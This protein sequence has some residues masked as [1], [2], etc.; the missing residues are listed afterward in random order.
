MMELLLG[1]GSNIKPMF[2]LG[3]ERC[4]QTWVCHPMNQSR[5]LML[6]NMHG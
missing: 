5:A 2:V 4:E 1:E 6:K 3:G